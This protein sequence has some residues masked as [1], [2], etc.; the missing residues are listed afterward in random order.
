LHYHLGGLPSVLMAGRDGLI[1]IVLQ[2]GS[3]NRDRN[4]SGL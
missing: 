1:Q 2:A 4:V 3:D